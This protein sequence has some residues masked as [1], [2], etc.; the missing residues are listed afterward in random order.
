N[1]AGFSIDEL[2]RLGWQIPLQGPS[3][4]LKATAGYVYMAASDRSLASGLKVYRYFSEELTRLLP[5]VTFEAIGNDLLHLLQQSNPRRVLTPFEQW[6]R[7]DVEALLYVHIPQIPSSRAMGTSA[8][9]SLDEYQ[10]RVPSDRSQW[11]TV[12]VPPRP[13]PSELRVTPPPVEAATIPGSVLALTAGC[14]F[15]LVWLGRHL[16]RRR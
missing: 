14:M 3:N 11:K 2:R 9:A 10:R 8:V 16:I 12:A 7:E 15:G 13:F 5:R 4:R 1:C 6:L